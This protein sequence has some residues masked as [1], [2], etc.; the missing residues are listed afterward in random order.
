MWI[1]SGCDSL[2]ALNALEQR[3]IGEISDASLNYRKKHSL[4]S[5]TLQ[6]LFLGIEAAK[7][8]DF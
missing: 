6:A 3:L 8:M 5:S 4:F 1:C 7:A 2:W